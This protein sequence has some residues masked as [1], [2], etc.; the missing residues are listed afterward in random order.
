MAYLTINNKAISYEYLNQIYSADTDCVLVFLHE[1]LG[2]VEQW[3]DFPDSL[4]KR[5]KIPALAYDRYGYGK[6]EQLTEK[7]PNNYLETEATNWLPQILTQLIPENKKTILIGHSDGGT[8]ALLY[9]SLFPNNVKA[10]ITEAATC[11]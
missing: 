7:R 8:I 11:L 10:V 4:S 2:S 5:L 9:A 3:K 1:G 6:S